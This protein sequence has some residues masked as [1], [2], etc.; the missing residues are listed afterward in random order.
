MGRSD[1]LG[2]YRPAKS[3]KLRW[4]KRLLEKVKA[5][6]EQPGPRKDQPFTCACHAIDL[7]KDRGGRDNHENQVDHCRS[8]SSI[9]VPGSRERC[10]A[11][12]QP[13][14][15]DQEGSDGQRATCGQWRPEQKA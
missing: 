4:L 5:A 8:D 14:S 10:G 6:I 13:N 9:G 11:I 1:G 12:V 15:L 3:S 2:E 7:E